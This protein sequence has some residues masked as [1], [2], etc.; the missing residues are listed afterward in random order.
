MP[1]EAQ[2]TMPTDAGSRPPGAERQ[3]LAVI[4][5]VCAGISMIV[6]S[7]VVI[8]VSPAEH[9]FEATK[10]IFVANLPLIGSWAGTVLAFYFSKDNL[11]AATKSV[12]DLH[13]TALTRGAAQDIPVTSKMIGKD[14]IVWLPPDLA[15]D[16][17]K[18]KAILDFADGRRITRLPI[19][20]DNCVLVRILH[21]SAIDRFIREQNK[22]S[23]ELT[24][25]QFLTAAPKT[26]FEKSFCVVS[27]SSTLADAKRKMAETPNCDDVFVTQSGDP[28]DPLLGWITNNIILQTEKV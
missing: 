25:H 16:T 24:L 26:S 12:A 4:V 27:A 28:K 3:W 14:R 19:L 6:L 17:T 9:R 22:S 8:I 18:L 7:A 13:Q 15:A 1:M 2:S 11:A 10:Y 21:V 23:D 20:G 5:L